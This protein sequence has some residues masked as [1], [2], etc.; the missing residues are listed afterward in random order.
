MGQRVY[1]E[2]QQR[3]D[4]CS[5]EEGK[6]QLGKE[7]WTKEEQGVDKDLMEGRYFTGIKGQTENWDGLERESETKGCTVNEPAKRV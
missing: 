7:L 5:D 1:E 3:C 4:L 2:R 6:E